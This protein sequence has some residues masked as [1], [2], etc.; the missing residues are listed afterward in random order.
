MRYGLRRNE[1]K[2]IIK[3]R[4]NNNPDIFY[5]IEDEYIEELVDL[6]SDGIADAIEANNK[7]LI[8]DLT[9]GLR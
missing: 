3:Q 2:R 4:I 9:K 6:I 7:K 5:Y 8:D 1:V